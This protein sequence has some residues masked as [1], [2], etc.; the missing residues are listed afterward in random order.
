M[1]W[2]NLCI[3]V[4]IGISDVMMHRVPN[5]A[6]L[7]L[8]L[9]NVTQLQGLQFRYLI[10]LSILL[11]IANTVFR[12]GMGDVKLVFI[13]ALIIGSNYFTLFL[14]RMLI[15]TTIWLCLYLVYSWHFEGVSF[16]RLMTIEIP[17]A[18]P[19]MIAVMRLLE[20]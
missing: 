18:P 9:F 7:T 3:L 8:L 1:F 17:L 5:I 13:L 14:P 20:R 15:A 2:I 6:L 4:W 19:I 12:V 16:Q 11:I 10:L